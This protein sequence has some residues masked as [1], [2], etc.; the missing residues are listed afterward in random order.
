M[1]LSAL[2]KYEFQHDLRAFGDGRK[3]LSRRAKTEADRLCQ[4]TLVERH[5]RVV[6]G[7]SQREISDFI[8]GRK[9]LPEYGKSISDAVEMMV[10][11]E[12]RIRGSNSTVAQLAPK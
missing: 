3:F 11:H 10:D 5:N 8:A 12:E 6:V 1:S 9:K 4:T 7:L 2:T